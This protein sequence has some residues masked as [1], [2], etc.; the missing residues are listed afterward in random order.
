MYTLDTSST[1]TAVLAAAA[2]TTAPTYT[3]TYSDIAL[4]SSLVT[5][6][7]PYSTTTGAMTGTTAVTIVASPATG[8]VREIENI[9]FRNKDTVSHTVTFGGAIDLSFTVPAGMV[10]TCNSKGEWQLGASGTVA[11][12][13]DVTGTST[14]SVVSKIGGNPVAFSGSTYSFT[15]TLTGNTAVTFPTTG[16]LASNSVTNTFSVN[17]KFN[18]GMDVYGNVADNALSLYPSAG[19]NYGVGVLLN[20]SSISGA[21]WQV[22]SSGTGDAYG[23]GNFQIINKAT[24][25]VT[26]M[27]T[28]TGYTSLGGAVTAPEKVTVG[29]NVAPVTAS[30]YYCG[31][32]ALPWAGGFTQTAFTVTSWSEKKANARCMTD[33]EASCAAELAEILCAYQY[34]DAITAKGTTSAR[35]HWGVIADTNTKFPDVG[36]VQAV[37]EKWGVDPLKMGFFCCDLVTADVPKT[38]THK[39]QKTK[40]VQTCEEQIITADDGTQTAKQVTVDAVVGVW[41]TDSDGND[42]WYELKDETGAVLTDSQGDVRR[43]RKPVMEDVTDVGTDRVYV[44]SNGEYSTDSASPL[45]TSAYSLRYEELLCF[46]IAGIKNRMNDLSGRVTALEGAK[47]T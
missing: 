32:S 17:Q 24:G 18:L 40:T 38:T 12:A 46:I 8:Y 37:C 33:S 47:S 42:I 26:Y 15:G 39:A 13:G 22:W 6:R 7:K 23:A 27:S 34:E 10:L 28:S 30:T 36:A 4:T 16:S 2:T 5:A 21:Q 3:I 35:W 29:G 41:E 19:R 43:Y 31:T 14:A 45:V 44:L 20:A 11:L 9:A 1:V 25:A